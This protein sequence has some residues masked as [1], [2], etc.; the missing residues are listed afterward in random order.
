M[1][2]PI[3]SSKNYIAE[4]NYAYQRRLADSL[5]EDLGVHGAVQWCQELGWD[6]VIQILMRRQN[7]CGS[8]IFMPPLDDGRDD[9][10]PSTDLD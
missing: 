1:S 8:R 9:A 2:H 5:L 6:G 3:M 10:L 4:E 7:A